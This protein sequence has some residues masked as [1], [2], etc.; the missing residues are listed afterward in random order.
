M[1][2]EAERK[3]QVIDPT[4]KRIRSTIMALRS[5]GPSSFASLT[6]N[7]GGYLQV[8]G[9]GVTCLL[10]WRDGATG[11]HYR[12]FHDTPSTVF[13][14]GTVLAFSGGRIPLHSDEWFTA[15]VVADAFCAFAKGL[16]LPDSIRW[17]SVAP[18]DEV[19]P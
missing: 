6:N 13:A 16:D 19:T 12:A 9:G 1:R 7:R 18:M 4:E 11:N 8:G 2:L 14:D 17:R 3:P 10:E 15:T 5:Y